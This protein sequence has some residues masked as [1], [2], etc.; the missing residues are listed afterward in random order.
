MLPV[1]FPAGVSNLATGLTDVDRDTL[2]LEKMERP[3]VKLYSVTIQKSSIELIETKYIMFT[4]ETVDPQADVL[5]INKYYLYIIIYNFIFYQK[6]TNQ[7]NSNILIF[8][9]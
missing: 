5:N 2:T 1:K 9:L 7:L 4:L 8:F 3:H 6:S